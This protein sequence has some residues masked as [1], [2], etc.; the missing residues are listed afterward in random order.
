MRL[1]FFSQKYSR[2]PSYDKTLQSYS[3]STGKIIKKKNPSFYPKKKCKLNVALLNVL[4]VDRL[5]GDVFDSNLAIKRFLWDFRFLLSMQ[6]FFSREIARQI[7]CYFAG[8]GSILSFYS[9]YAFIHVEPFRL[10]KRE[11]GYDYSYTAPL[12]CFKHL[13]RHIPSVRLIR[14]YFRGMLVSVA[15]RYLD[16]NTK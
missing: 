1:T 4:S 5:L 7:Y 8:L 13:I 15:I 2:L 12:I 10:V 16:S 11:G 6:C 14:F 9:W 3:F